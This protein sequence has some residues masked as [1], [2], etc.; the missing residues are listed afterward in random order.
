MRILHWLSRNHTFPLELTLSCLSIASELIH[1]QDILLSE[2]H[3]KYMD[4]DSLNH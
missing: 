3:C 1:P 2:P 4:I